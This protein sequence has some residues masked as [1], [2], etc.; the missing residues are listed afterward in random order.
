M[1]LHPTNAMPEMW[2]SDLDDESLQNQMYLATYL[3]HKASGKEGHW[4]LPQK[5]VISTQ[6]EEYWLGWL[7]HSPANYTYLWRFVYHAA[8]AQLT[9]ELVSA[10]WFDG[11]LGR[12]A[13]LMDIPEC[14]TKEE[15][16][17]VW[18]SPNAMGYIMFAEA[19]AMARKWYTSRWG[20]SMGGSPKWSG[21][22]PSWYCGPG[23]QVESLK[24][25]LFQF[26]QG[27]PS[28]F[29]SMLAMKKFS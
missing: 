3:L 29:E 24:K 13:V 6:M 26:K 4:E 11:F 5:I 19:V 2:A 9:R 15:L 18:P 22:G 27:S 7:K 16:V 1:S 21:M 10:K 12:L 8:E 17:E 14:L 20:Q 23:E 28:F 25:S